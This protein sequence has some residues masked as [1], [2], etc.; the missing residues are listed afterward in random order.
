MSGARLAVSEPPIYLSW[1]RCCTPQTTLTSDC[2]RQG[3]ELINYLQS[4]YMPKL[5][6]EPDTVQRFCQA[7]RSDSKMFRNYTKVR[8]VVDGT[9]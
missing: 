1:C 2:P 7:L 8:R 9:G 5:D 4:Q 6:I 3:E